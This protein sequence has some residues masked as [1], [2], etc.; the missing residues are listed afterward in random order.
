MLL[1][2]GR[3][4]IAGPNDEVE[5]PDAD[6]SRATRAQQAKSVRGAPAIIR[7]S[8]GRPRAQPPAHHSP[9]QLLSGSF[10]STGD[11]RCGCCQQGGASES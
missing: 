2:A 6:A 3:W 8:E 4:R 5:R 11:I 7:L 1:S 10:T 9:L